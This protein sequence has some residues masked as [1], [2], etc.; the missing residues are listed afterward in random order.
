MKSKLRNEMRRMGRR[1]DDLWDRR[2]RDR[3]PFVQTKRALKLNCIFLKY[4]GFCYLLERTIGSR[5]P[6]ASRI[7]HA[8]AIPV[9][10]QAFVSLCRPAGSTI[11]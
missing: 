9:V 1:Y 2:R 3:T 10:A 11:A 7:L 4:K 8:H 5:P 6:T